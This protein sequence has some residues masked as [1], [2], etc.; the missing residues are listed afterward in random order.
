M[1]RQLLLGLAAIWLAAAPLGAV[2]QPSH[3][4]AGALMQEA[5]ALAARIHRFHSGPGAW[6]GHSPPPPGYCQVMIQ[7]ELVQ[8]ELAALASKTILY[9]P[10]GLVLP[11]QRA[12]DA[13]SDALDQ[14][15]E[16]NNQAGF[17]YQPN[18]YPCP[19]P[20]S[21]FAARAGV[22]VLVNQRMPK[23]RVEANALRLSFAARRNLMQQCLRVRM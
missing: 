15:E 22:L 1:H 20:S 21:P 11:L 2:G 4:S 5:A 14:E 10:P 18:A 8:K 12:G 16:I 13:L 9:G 6:L 17:N 7:G 23:C 19:A 3:R